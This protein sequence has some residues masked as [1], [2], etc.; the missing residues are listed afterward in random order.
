MQIG[1]FNEIDSSPSGQEKQT[2]SSKAGLSALPDRIIDRDINHF[3][4][5]HFNCLLGLFKQVFS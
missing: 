4:T 1:L 3:A 2:R 5:F